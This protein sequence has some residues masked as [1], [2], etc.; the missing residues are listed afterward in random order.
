[1]Q[2]HD[3][4]VPRAGQDVLIHRVR[5][6]VFPVERV[7]APADDRRGDRVLHG[8]AQRTAG[9]AHHVGIAAAH[10]AEQQLLHLPDLAG[11]GRRGLG[12]ERHDV[13]VCMVGELMPLIPHTGEHRALVDDA[14]AAVDAGHEKRGRRAACPEPVQQPRRV[15]R[16]A[17]V[18]RKRNQLCAA[19]RGRCPCRAR[20][21]AAQQHGE[22]KRARKHPFS[23]LHRCSLPCFSLLYRRRPGPSICG[24]GLRFAAAFGILYPY[25]HT[26]GKPNQ[27]Q[28]I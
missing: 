10:I 26:E 22:R 18:K 1:M 11:N 15:G 4:A 28:N 7:H 13:A 16:R 20:R 9:R 23:H 12:V 17:V 19:R 25:F 8:R 2:Q 24:R 3:R 5:V 27:W 14:A 21:H 6:A